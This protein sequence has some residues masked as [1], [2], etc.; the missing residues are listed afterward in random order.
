MS[1][2]TFK[3]DAAAALPGELKTMEV[4]ASLTNDYTFTHIDNQRV[5]GKKGDIKAVDN[6]SG[7][8]YYIEVKNDSRIAETGNVLCEYQKYFADTN[9]YKPG[10]MSYDYEVFIV[11]SIKNHYLY[12]IDF[13]KLRTFYFTGRYV[14]IRYP[15]ETTYGYL[16]K[17]DEIKRRGALMNVIQY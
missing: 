12:V 9:T 2:S 7:K 10:C 15:D 11:N 5:L 4:L 8:T 6:K 3:H 13:S 14:E 1:Y 16:V 17:L